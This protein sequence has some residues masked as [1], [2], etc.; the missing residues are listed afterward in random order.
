V[1]DR[2]QAARRLGEILYPGPEAPA[3][4]TRLQDAPEPELREAAR[5]S[6]HLIERYAASRNPPA[7]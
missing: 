3:A 1:R 6:L 5:E 4:L 2:V 7:A